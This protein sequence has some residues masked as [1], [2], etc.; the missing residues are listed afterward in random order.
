MCVLLASCARPPVRPV[1]LGTGETGLA[2]WYGPEF[3]GRPTSSGEVYD[4]YQ[5]T[6]AHRELPLGTW[7]MVTNLHN[8]RSVE[9]RVNDRGPFVP[10]RILDVSYGAGRLLGMIGPGVIPVRVVVTR[11]V[12]GDGAEPTPL[13]AR[14]TVQ[15]GSFVSEGNARDLAHSLVGSF[16]DVEVVRRA[17]GGDVYYR[18]RIG[19]LDRRAE[20]LALAERLAA[21]GLSVLILERDR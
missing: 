8:G 16:P 11:R 21:R 10:D 4:M 1:S 3:H 9:L 18:V 14:Y 12:L 13:T 19:N 5:L 20:A 6:A 7:V 15:L 17:I 2:S